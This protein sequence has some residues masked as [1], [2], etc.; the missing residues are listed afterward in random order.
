M[1]LCALVWF[2]PA[3]TGWPGEAQGS[4][5]WTLDEAIQYALANS[6][7]ARIARHRV[8]A[9]QA[10]IQ[11]A[12]AAFWPKASLSSS[13][14][15]TD[16]PVSVFSHALNQGVFELG[17]FDLNDP[18]DADNW[19]TTGMLKMPLF[20]GGAHVAAKASAEAH[21]QATEEE[22]ISVHN[23][24]GFEVAR[25]FF[26]IHKNQGFI[27]AAEAAVDSYETHV[28]LGEIRLETGT[29]LESDLLNLE[30]QLASAREDLLRAQN[31]KRI[32]TLVFANLLGLEEIDPAIASS[33]PDVP[34]PMTAAENHP[35]ILA[36]EHRIDA[37][38]AELKKARSGYFPRL[39]IFGSYQ[40][41]QGWEMDGE[42]RSWTVGGVLEWELWDG[43]LTRGRANQASAELEEAREQHRKTARA[44]DLRIRQARLNLDE[45]SERLKVTRKAAEQ[46]EQSA[47]LNRS[48][49]EQGLALASELIDAET[50]L[51]NARV[52]HAQAQADRLTA[53]S[54]LRYAMGLTQVSHQKNVRHDNELLP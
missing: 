35:D 17:S 1:P 46:A 50:A 8:D 4:S 54:A 7:D 9:A 47:Q 43:Q 6:P 18:P 37:A 3:A 44:V 23:R 5:P 36:S 48:R 27:E 14:S 22:G 49:F 42:G 52:R 31:A 40:R 2:V 11:Q 24:L 34:L 21:F 19:N 45:A 25:S 26:L 33:L 39:S 15:R 29:M 10:M 12:N 30:V 13:Y 16:N 20:A 38:Q 32:A 53:H 51:T 41:D 28:R